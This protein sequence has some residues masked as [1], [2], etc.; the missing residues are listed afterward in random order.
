MHRFEATRKVS[1][2]PEVVF[3]Y[4]VDPDNGPAWSSS[5]KSVRAEGDEG[6]GRK[7][8]TKAGMMGMTFDV[9]NE[10]TAYDRPSTYAFGGSSPFEVSFS[11][12]IQADGDGSAVTGVVEVDPGKFFP[13][14][15]K[16]VARQFK[17]IF[18]KDVDSLMKNIE[19]L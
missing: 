9:E 6:V 2:P 8:I 10:V 4:I 12:D 18:E 5:A 15:G 14:G 16:L 1:K 7:L 3:D 13:V 19:A 11:F 17:K